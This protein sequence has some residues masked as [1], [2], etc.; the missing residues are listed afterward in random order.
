MNR[1]QR[2]AEKPRGGPAPQASVQAEFTA[3]LR[4]HQAGHLKEAERLYRRILTIDSRHADSLHLLGL[5][6]HHDGR[7][8]L[9]VD[10]IGQAIA[11]NGSE[12]YYHSN[13]GTALWKWGRLDAAA[14]SYRRALEL[15]PDYAK[16]HFNLATV[17]W[18][19]G[20]P[21]EAMAGFRTALVH[22]PD[23]PEAHDNLGTVLK[24]QGRTAE[25]IACYQA[26]L[27]LRPAYP[28]AHNN[29]GTAL[30]EQGNA[31]AAAGCY[32]HAIALRP[33]YPEAHFNLGTAILEQ[34][35][36]EAATACFRTALAQ[37]PDYP[38]AFLNLGTTLKQLGRLEHATACYRE[39]LVR[40]P[41]HPEAHSNLGIVLLA[42]G[43]LE[44]GW[45]EHEWRW[46]TPQMI[47]ARRGFTQPQWRGE[48]AGGRTLLIHAEQGFGDTLEFCRYAPMA[49]ARGLRVILE[50]QRPLVRLLRGLPGVDL[51]I[52]HGEALPAF[53][54]H[55]PMLSLPLALRTTLATIPG[56]APYLHADP[57]AVAAW[58]TRL[59]AT[60]TRGPRIGLAWAGNPRD[61]SRGLAAVDRRRS[62]APELL[63]PLFEVPGVNFVSL[64]KGGP[65]APADFPLAGFMS[66]MD[67]FADTAA[68]VA[69][70]DLVISVDTA[71]VHLA[72]GLGCPVWLLDRF[73]PC[74]RWL[75]GR[76][77]SP[78]YPGLRI[79]RQPSPGDWES[80]ME[81][82]VC[83][84]RCLGED[85]TEPAAGRDTILAVAH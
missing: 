21:D 65:G 54:L 27:R 84:L 62:M 33:A 55:C 52:A 15:R 24:E 20:R 30:L 17:L 41:D 11:I 71:V 8:D 76:R 10:L 43:K 68:L 56:D 9:A 50:V 72:A 39:V 5:V 74:W 46:R 26:A 48:A 82:V 18:K 67:D 14:A 12:A 58:R 78:W 32:R 69:N 44:E 80:V 63:A 28:E 31:D 29:L 61:H 79:Y 53:D 35:G 22:Q 51:V 42:Q 70:L 47:K 19:Q 81:E 64:Q 4:Y 38:D 6:A 45:E 23:Y 34:G 85:R 60:A 3:A 75:T 57:A 36:P 73:D 7:H 49:A 77:D 66:E 37:R 1:K 13:L 2:R 16:A 40:E 59:T 25:A 83:Y